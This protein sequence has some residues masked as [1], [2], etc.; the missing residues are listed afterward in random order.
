MVSTTFLFNCGFAGHST[1]I[2]FTHNATV[3]SSPNAASMEAVARSM[4]GLGQ[5]ID[6]MVHEGPELANS[7]I[8]SSIRALV[9][10]TADIDFRLTALSSERYRLLDF[11]PATKVG[12]NGLKSPV[13]QTKVPK[14]SDGSPQTGQSEG[15]VI[16]IW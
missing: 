14:F 9:D 7:T 2:D 4:K 3:F 10:G 6:V 1:E 16:G 5:E 8:G 12:T 11:G 15:C 13:T